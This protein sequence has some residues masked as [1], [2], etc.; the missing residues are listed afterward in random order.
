MKHYE[1][2]D[3]LTQSIDTALAN[4]HTVTIAK[5]TKVDATTI[6]CRPVINRQ[7]DGVSIAL[8]EFVDVPPIFMQGGSSYTAYPIAIG[9]YCLLIFTERCFDRWYAGQDYQLPLELRMHDYSDGLAL[10]GINPFAAA[11][12]IPTVIQQTGDTHQNGDYTHIGNMTRTGDLIQTGDI[13]Q[14]GILTVT[15]SASVTE[16]FDAAAISVSGTQGI[17]GSFPTNDGR[18]VTI[19]KGIITAVV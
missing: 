15:G 2:I 6:N 1:L 19:T 8:P 16:G 5:V 4:V 9:D 13:N 7:V 3:I 14:T 18:T 11:L 12:T 10:V 17:D